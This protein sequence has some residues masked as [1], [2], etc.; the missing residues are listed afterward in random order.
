MNLHFPLCAS[1]IIVASATYKMTQHPSK[2]TPAIRWYF[3]GGLGV[4]LVT[5]ALI[6]ATHRGLDPTGTTRLGRVSLVLRLLSLMLTN[7]YT[8]LG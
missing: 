3:S 1:L 2:V 4:A 6:G 8:C 5:L 7:T